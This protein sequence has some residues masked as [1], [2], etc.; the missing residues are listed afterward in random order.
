MLSA[1]PLLTQQPG[2]A[3]A[4]AA[5][6][7]AA[8]VHVRVFVSLASAPGNAQ[9]VMVNPSAASMADVLGPVCAKFGL[10]PAADMHLQLEG[11]GVEV[12]SPSEIA[13]NDKLVLVVGGGPPGYAE[14]A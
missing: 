9:I 13:A 4:R 6:A 12:S 3:P 2:F 7:A 11:A 10:N 8:A 1:G 14:K 5:T